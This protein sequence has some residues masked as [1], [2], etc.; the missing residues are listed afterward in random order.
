MAKAKKLPSGSWRVQVY[1]CTDADGKKHYASF[2]CGTKK[3]AEFLAAEFALEKNRSKRP[4]DMTVGKAIEKY[5]ESKQNV[6]ASSTLIGYN[7]MRKLYYSDLE[8]LALKNLTN[9]S[10]QVWVSGLAKEHSPKTVSNARVLLVSALDMFCPD[11]RIK[12]TLPARK[13]PD[14][15]T[16]SDADVQQLLNH[17]KGKELEIAVLLA[18][19]GPMRRGEIC[20]VTSDDVKGNVI[21]VNKSMTEV[22]GGGWDIKQPKTY[23]SYRE[24]EY[25]Q[26]VIDRIA[27]IEGRLVKATPEQITSRFRRAVKFSGVPKFRF[28]DLRHYAASIMHALGVPDQYIMARGGWATDGVMKSVYRSTIDDQTALNNAKIFDHFEKISHEIQHKNQNN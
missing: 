16:P 7:K 1:D 14:L 22:P 4:A 15:Y 3:E 21:T 17:I 19:Y 25:P 6:L 9:E 28:H 18:A 11:L 5:I 8:D 20:A 12:V 23:S 13:K 27:G 24:I 26:F 2:T 10:V